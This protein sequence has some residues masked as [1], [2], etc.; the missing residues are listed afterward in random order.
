MKMITEKNIK[1]H[2]AYERTYLP[3]DIFYISL[4]SNMSDIDISIFIRKF[5]IFEFSSCK[6]TEFKKI[7]KKIEEAKLEY[8]ILREIIQ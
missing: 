8:F 4:I 5:Q 6:F 7:K 2:S 1:N 3:S